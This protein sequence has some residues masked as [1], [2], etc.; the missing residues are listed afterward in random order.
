MSFLF[1]QGE[2]D[3]EDKLK[4]VFNAEKLL[5]HTSEYWTALIKRTLLDTPVACVRAFPSTKKGDELAAAEEGRLASRAESL[6]EQGLA[7]LAAKLD[8]ANE[9]NNAPIP[10]SIVSSFDVPDVQNVPFIPIVTATY[11]SP[12]PSSPGFGE[13]RVL[14]QKL[15]QGRDVGAADGPPFYI[16]FDHVP[17]DF[18]E[19]T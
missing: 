1:G 12:L 2:H 6:G 18:C 7:S 17:S 11:P 16:Q 3:C 13:G 4:S 9:A 14:R 19:V 8:Q 10:P 15:D 5:T